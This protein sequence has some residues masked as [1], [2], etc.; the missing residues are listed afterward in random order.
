[1]MLQIACA[2]LLD[3]LLGDPRWLPHPVRFIARLAKWIEARLR[4]RMQDAKVAG[5]LTLLA[6]LA[7]STGSVALFLLCMASLH[8]VAHFI[9]GTLVIY[10]TIAAR[11]LI[12]H[13]KAVYLT[14]QSASIEEARTCV[15]RIVGRETESLDA[16]GITRAAVETVAEST[17]D[18]VTAPLFYAILLGPLGAIAYRTIN[19]LD[20]TFGY[21]TTEYLHF[22]WA[23]ARLDDLANYLPARLT[24]PLMAVAA[25]CSGHNATG[26]WRIWRRDGHKHE[27]PNAGHVEAAMAGALDIQLGGTNIYEGE[28]LEKPTLGDAITPLVPEHITQANRLMTLTYL[29]FAFLGILA[30]SIIRLPLRIVAFPRLL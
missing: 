22:G 2:M 17:V 24:A 27:S 9:A 25:A 23:S 1:M 7:I 28:P 29:L 15:A 14:L 13:S 19:T 21:R 16:A 10:T 4:P 26:A 18:G 20:S 12:H 11:D 30:H 5:I 6:T 3:A 8:P